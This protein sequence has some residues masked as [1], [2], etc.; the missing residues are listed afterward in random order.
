MVVRRLGVL[1]LASTLCC[2]GCGSGG[3][4]GG[5]T[6][7]V[8]STPEIAG[9][10]AGTLT[11]KGL[12]P[13]RIAVRISPDGTGRVAYT[14]IECGGRW[15]LKSALASSPPAGYNFRE[16]ITQ[17]TGGNCKGRG[18]VSIGPD[19]PRAPKKLGYG[20]TGGGVSSEGTLHKTDA[21]GLKPVFDEAGVTPP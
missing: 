8:V 1:V 14:G 18:V 13:F 9:D 12:A 17:G 6:T 20:F 10:W 4:D 2:A 15:T 16:R 3:N 7:A 5:T 21:A 19:S 11:Q